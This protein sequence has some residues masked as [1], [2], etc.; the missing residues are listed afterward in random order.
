MTVPPVAT[1]ALASAA[2][3]L[4]ATPYSPLGW[5]Q[6]MVARGYGTE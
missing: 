4:A 6:L 1:A 2:G 5:V 3:L